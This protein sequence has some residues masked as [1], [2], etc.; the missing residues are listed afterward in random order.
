[1]ADRFVFGFATIT[2]HSLSSFCCLTHFFLMI[3]STRFV[4]ACYN[5]SCLLLLLLLLVLHASFNVLF[6]FEKWGNTRNNLICYKYTQVLR[7]CGSSSSGRKEAS[8]LCLLFSSDSVNLASKRFK[9][10]HVILPILFSSFY[11]SSFSLQSFSSIFSHLLGIYM[12]AETIRKNKLAL[13][14]FLIKEMVS[15]FPPYF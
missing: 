15:F 3:I 13:G 2:I 12:Y 8:A 5:F 14:E 6:F 9:G 11:F 4:A 1:M 10:F 7:K